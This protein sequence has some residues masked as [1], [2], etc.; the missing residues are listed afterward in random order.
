MAGAG[1]EVPVLVELRGLVLP[2]AE[3]V[4]VER[5]VESSLLNYLIIY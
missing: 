4:H 1:L 5:E 3:L 2:V